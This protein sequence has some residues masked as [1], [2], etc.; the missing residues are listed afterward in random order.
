MY[1]EYNLAQDLNLNLKLKWS[2]GINKIK[3]KEEK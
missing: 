2:L 1:F 3:R